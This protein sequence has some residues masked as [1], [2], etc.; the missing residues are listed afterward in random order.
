M[1][2][3]TP[4]PALGSARLPDRVRATDRPVSRAD[5]VAGL[6]QLRHLHA[7]LEDAL[8]ACDSPALAAL[9]DPAR[10]ARTPLLTA[11]IESLGHDGEAPGPA[12]PV[13]TLAE[14]LR[15]WAADR[16][17]ALAG[18]LYV[19][20]GARAGSA[21]VAR[22]LTRALAVPPLPGH[23]LDYHLDGVATR[24]ADWRAFT[25]RLAAL[26]LTDAEQ[27]DVLDAAT[28]TTAA[29]ASLNAATPATPAAEPAVA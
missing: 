21:T 6:H 1:V 8:A 28:A 25:A 7:A 12:A 24:T 18:A 14:L 17:H 11:D 9:Y 27:A 23:G 13:V 15:E 2:E 10:M 5:Y 26:P 29:L 16:P 20:E 19:T 22:S 3:M 4:P